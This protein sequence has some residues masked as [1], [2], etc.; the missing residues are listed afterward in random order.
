M[1]F[2][3]YTFL[4][5]IAGLGMYRLGKVFDQVPSVFQMDSRTPS[6]KR[7]PAKTLECKYQAGDLAKPITGYG[8]TLHEARADASQ[9]CFDVRMHRVDASS[10]GD[11]EYINRGLIN[12]D[13][14]ANI[15]CS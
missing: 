1:K 14:C 6:S 11:S 8:S 10:A 4:I 3:W 15:R 13:E 5:V 7:V 9:K 12:I 2:L